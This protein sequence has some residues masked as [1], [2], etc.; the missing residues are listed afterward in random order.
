MTKGVI[1]LKTNR[2]Q[3]IISILESRGEMSVGALSDY[4]GVSLSTLRKQLAEMQSKRLII[5]TYGGVI[6]A[7]RIPDETFES[8]LHKSVAEKRRIAAYARRLLFDGASV[9]LG[10]GT[11]VYAL[12]NLL[13]DMN[14]ATIYTNSMQS[15]DFLSRCPS[16]EVQ[17]CGG[18][19]RS[20]TGTIIGNDA[21]N[22]F[23]GLVADFAF[24]GC[25][26][27]DDAGVVY[28]DNIAVAAVE[29]TLL[30]NA[31][32]RYVLCDS[33]KLGKSSIA[34]ITNLADCDALITGKSNGYIV[35][36]L[37]YGANVAFA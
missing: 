10:S 4:L 26:A 13:D 14:H 27:I 33:S 29:S 34:R 5:R 20:S 17:I 6:S 2:E 25:D 18:L 22:F 37:A 23:N 9:S 28:S 8:K 7:N 3:K 16:L 21:F 19:V 11:T 32:H 36:K 12:C 15:A 31:K 24:I 35:E 1:H 30:K